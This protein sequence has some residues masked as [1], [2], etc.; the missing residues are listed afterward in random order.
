M[1]VRAGFSRATNDGRELRQLSRALS[2]VRHEKRAGTK[3]GAEAGSVIRGM[4]A[5]YYRDGD[6][7]TEYWL[8]DDIVERLMPG[9]FDR[10]ISEAHDARALFNHDSNQLLGR[11]SSGTCRLS[12]DSTGLAYEID[13]DPND[14]DS[15]RV[16]AKIDRGDV[17][18]S[19]FGF[20]P[21]AVRWLEE[22]LDSGDW[23][24]IRE[25]VDV[26]LFD[27][28][29]VTWPAYSGTTAGRSS[30]PSRAIDSAD[31][32]EIAYLRRERDQHLRPADDD[33]VQMRLRLIELDR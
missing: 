15:Q 5:V 24:Y 13:A 33:A 1:Q 22:K 3:D 8:W 20:I 23:L 2:G 10:A 27:V 14:P 29:P 25:V 4:A 21:R 12:L 11:V 9:C 18:G 17:N 31:S 6:T 19:S 28:G 7:A 26:D 16:A 32:A 30:A